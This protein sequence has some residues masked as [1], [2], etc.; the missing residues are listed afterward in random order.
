MAIVF[1]TDLGEGTQKQTRGLEFRCMWFIKEVIPRLTGK[2][3]GSRTGKGE[4][5]DKVPQR[6]AST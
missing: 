5:T 3:V 4:V 6:V 1:T 2:G